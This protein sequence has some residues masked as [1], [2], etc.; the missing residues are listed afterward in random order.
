MYSL[1]FDNFRWNICL[2]CCVNICKCNN[3]KNYKGGNIFVGIACFHW[4]IFEIFEIQI[5]FDTFFFGVIWDVLFDVICWNKCVFVLST[6]IYKSCL[7][8]NINFCCRS[9]D[10]WKAPPTTQRTLKSLMA[11]KADMSWHFNFGFLFFFFWLSL[12][13]TTIHLIELTFIRP[14]LNIPVS[15]FVGFFNILFLVKIYA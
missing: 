7:W 3:K 2:L 15:S 8:R 14:I 9:I 4:R 6:D 13:N 11:P 10:F 12:Q 1:R 5:S